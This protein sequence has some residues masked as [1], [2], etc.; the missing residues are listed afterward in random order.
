VENGCRT[1]STIT[2]QITQK[3][4]VND[5]IGL[6]PWLE[7]ATREELLLLF[8]EPASD[9]SIGGIDTSESAG[10]GHVVCIAHLHD[11]QPGESAKP[12]NSSILIP[13]Q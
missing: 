1:V 4:K 7:V 3:N 5:F 9:S 2:R 12:S 13:A 10:R 6:P 11:V 8:A